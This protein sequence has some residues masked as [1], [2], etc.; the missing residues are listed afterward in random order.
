MA[1]T[2]HH[3]AAAQPDQEYGNGA[4]KG[5]YE[6]RGNEQ[7]H[8]AGQRS[9]I[10]PRDGA[11]LLEHRV[12]LKSVEN[13]ECGNGGEKPKGKEWDSCRRVG[14]LNQLGPLMAFLFITCLQ[15]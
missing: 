2:T 4:S 14:G 9:G 12:G 10:R 5:D 13:D 3:N 11:V 7:P 6:R 8:Q 15:F 1:A